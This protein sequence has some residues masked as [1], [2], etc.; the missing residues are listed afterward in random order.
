MAKA[1]KEE[2]EVLS[3][4]VEEIIDKEIDSSLVKQ[5][6]TDALLSK[7][8][9]DY[10]G[11]KINGPEDKE[12]YLVVQAARKDC[13][14]VRVL[15][16]KICKMGRAKANAEAKKWVNKENELV[17][18]V[19]KVENVLEADEKEYERVREQEKQLKA[20]KMEQQGIQRTSD[21]MGFGAR[22][23]AGNWL[24][25]D[26]SYE[27]VLIKNCDE[28]IYQGI[29]DQFKAIFDVNEK[30]KADKAEEDRLANEKLLKDQEDLKRLQKEAKD[31]RTQ[32]R[33]SFLESL[34]M[35]RSRM[36]DSYIYADQIVSVM[37]INEKESQDWEV[38]IAGVRDGID[39]AQASAKEEERVEEVFKKRLVLLREWSSDGRYVN[40]SFTQGKNWGTVKQLVDLPEEDFDNLI[41]QNETFLHDRDEKIKQ[42]Q[43]QQIENARIEGI[44]KSRREMLK[45]INTASGA[46]DFELGSIAGEQWDQDLKTATQLHNKVK[47]DE[48]DRKE[49]ERLSLLGEKAQYEELVAKL[50]DIPVPVLKSGQYA[51]KANA[52]RNFIDGLK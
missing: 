6:V 13:K 47:K 2:I 23:E 40:G 35:G 27:S 19:E 21:M 36:G 7:L 42:Q 10:G 44:G 45:S 48:D 41:G 39:R 51:G 22:L 49:K 3:P 37:D 11:L 15:I 31:M 43:N 17:D 5:N 4:E 38:V 32:G 12:G 26:L 8:E 52:I 20:Q 46:S 29:R 28:D 34:G 9:K 25:G 18:R 14:S 1:A 33:V 30:A 24:S 50:K 16:S